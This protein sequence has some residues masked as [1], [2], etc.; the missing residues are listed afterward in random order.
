MK[1]AEV[2]M[3]GWLLVVRD[4]IELFCEVGNGGV[5]HAENAWK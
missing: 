4:M 5:Y 1:S 3:F 2:E